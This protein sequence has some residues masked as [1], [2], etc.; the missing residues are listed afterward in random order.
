[1]TDEP[2]VQSGLM[3]GPAIGQ[4]DY[5]WCRCRLGACETHTH[6]AGGT[7][8]EARRLALIQ[9]PA[10]LE[11]WLQDEAGPDRGGGASTVRG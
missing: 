9:W 3:T 6:I 11:R 8:D 1:M 5:A 7:E 4:P 2:H 10:A